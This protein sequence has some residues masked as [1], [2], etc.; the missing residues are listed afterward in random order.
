MIGLLGLN[1]KIGAILGGLG[2]IILG[3][4]CFF[5]RVENGQLKLKIESLN[6]EITVVRIDLE[7][8]RANSATLQ[9]AVNDQNATITAIS[10]ESQARL[11]EA[12]AKLAVAQKARRSAEARA[13]VLLGTKFT[14][15]TLE[16]RVLEVDS[17]V[18]ETLK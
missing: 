3:V 6:K 2:T 8:A 12:N 16:Q 4:A 15:S 1:W 13:A 10:K 7:Q 17:K 9:S 14:G 18:L 5:L 11:A